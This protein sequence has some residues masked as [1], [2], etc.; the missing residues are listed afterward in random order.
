MSV[1]LLVF[2]GII[3]AP[4][5]VSPLRWD[6]YFLFPELFCMLLASAGVAAIAGLI[7]N[8]VWR[9]P[10]KPASTS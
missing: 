1:F 2:I 3:S 4:A 8:D 5:L 7:F 6:R 9:H 10:L